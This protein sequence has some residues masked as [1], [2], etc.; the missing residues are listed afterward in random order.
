MLINTRKNHSGDL[1]PTLMF[2]PLVM[3]TISGY[4]HFFPLEI[5]TSFWGSFLFL[6]HF[7]YEAM[8]AFY[9]V[10]LLIYTY[11]VTF[12]TSLMF[13]TYFTGSD[14]LLV[15]DAHFLSGK[16]QAEICEHYF[17]ETSI[18]VQ[19]PSVLCF[20]EKLSKMKKHCQCLSYSES[21]YLT[22]QPSVNQAASTFL[23]YF[24]LNFSFF[25]FFKLTLIYS[26]LL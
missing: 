10:L 13:Q 14:H 4:V 12:K 8:D 26:F 9:Y 11:A 24:F 6:Q 23:P 21:L 1:I 15:S 5:L 20:T 2:S 22:V 7:V 16:S 3:A 19:Y 17:A 25:F 18:S